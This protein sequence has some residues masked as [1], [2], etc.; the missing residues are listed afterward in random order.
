MT[1]RGERLRHIGSI[2]AGVIA[3]LLAGAIVAFS[4]VEVP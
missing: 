1:G 3:I 4:H 2:V